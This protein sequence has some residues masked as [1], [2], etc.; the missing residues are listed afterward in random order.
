MTKIMCLFLVLLCIALFSLSCSTSYDWENEKGASDLMAKQQERAKENTDPPAAYKQLKG[1]KLNLE[2]NIDIAPTPAPH[3]TYV[4]EYCPICKRNAG[5]GH[6]HGVTMWCEICKKEVSSLESQTAEGGPHWHDPLRKDVHT[7]WC[8]YCNR[9][10][11]TGHKHGIEKYQ[12]TKFC[13]ICMKEMGVEHLHWKDESGKDVHTVWCPTCWQEVG[14]GHDHM[15]TKFCPT[16]PS[17]L[18]DEGRF[19][20]K[21][22]KTPEFGLQKDPNNPEKIPNKFVKGY[23]DPVPYGHFCGETR[24]SFSWGVDLPIIGPHSKIEYIVLD[25]VLPDEGEI[26]YRPAEQPRIAMPNPEDFRKVFPN[27]PEEVSSIPWVEERSV[28]IDPDIFA[29]LQWKWKNPELKKL[30]MELAPLKAKDVAKEAWDYFENARNP[31]FKWKRE[32]KE[33]PK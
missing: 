28:T 33:T 30:V 14:P 5:P 2:D 22:K 25:T 4:T 31:E 19:G 29:R 27:M 15:L 16:S 18:Q 17:C 6:I 12:E 9:E 7:D 11:F 26:H 21:E 10:V 32:E 1:T 20:K 3:T 24:Y 23:T 13:Y 8:Y